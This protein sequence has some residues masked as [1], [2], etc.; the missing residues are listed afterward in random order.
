[1]LQWW[2]PV[3]LY[4]IM[5]WSRVAHQNSPKESKSYV[6]IYRRGIEQ[7]S[8][9]NIEWRWRASSIL[10]TNIILEFWRRLVAET[11]EIQQSC[12][13]GHSSWLAFEAIKRVAEAH[14]PPICRMYYSSYWLSCVLPYC[15]K[16]HKRSFIEIPE[17][18]L[19]SV[20]NVSISI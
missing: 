2:R 9:A 10:I 8:P 5:K 1:M 17:S 15:A 16:T 20:I 13:S 12:Q 14:H 3:V 7:S 19:K 4:P 6:I 11:L 18:V